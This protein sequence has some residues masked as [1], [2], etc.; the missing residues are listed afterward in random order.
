MTDTQMMVLELASK[1]YSCAQIVILGGL[2]LLERENPDLVRAAGGLAQGGGNSGS[3]CGALSGGFS[4]LSLYTAKGKDGEV[5]HEYA[6]IL[7]NEL[8]HR[9]QENCS[10]SGVITC[11]A[12][13][14][15]SADGAERAMNTQRCAELVG[16]VWEEC[17]K[18]LMEYGFDPR[19]GRSEI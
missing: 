17:V 18:L 5:A 6:D 9:F 1:Q 15:F 12:L 8:L 2:R 7:H 11:D 16:W 13:L 14:D 19:E 4:F 3:L 10:S